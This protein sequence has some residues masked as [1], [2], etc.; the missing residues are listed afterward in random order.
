MKSLQTLTA[1]I[2]LAI[3]GCG[4]SPPPAEVGGPAPHFK[5]TE[6][7]TDKPVDSDSLKGNDVV[8]LNF[9]S[10]TCVSCLK[11]IE[12]LKQISADG[13]AEVIGIV[14]GGS[15][16]QV[17]KIVDTL[18][19]EYPV[20]AGNEELFTQYDGYSLPYTLVLDA[21]LTIRRKIFGRMDKEEFD[22]VIQSIKSE[23]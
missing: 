9:W 4:G 5:L 10:T 16:E 17:K 8:V 21:N 7:S 19:I 23:T 22:Q 2:L 3:T 18:G 11:E 6:V 15:P 20:L 12:D 13:T 14:L 1:C